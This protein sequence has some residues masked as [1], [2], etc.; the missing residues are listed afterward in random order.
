MKSEYSVRKRLKNAKE[1]L[2][3]AQNR[4]EN[5]IIK[6]YDQGMQYARADMIVWGREVEILEWLLKKK[7]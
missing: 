4:L 2:K 5:F 1:E 7:K 6:K 3:M